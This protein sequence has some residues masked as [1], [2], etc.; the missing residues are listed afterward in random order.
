MLVKRSVSV[1]VGFADFVA[2]NCTSAW[3]R[4]GSGLV[5][6]WFTNACAIGFEDVRRR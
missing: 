1:Y 4:A 6:N 3:F 5:S 2:S